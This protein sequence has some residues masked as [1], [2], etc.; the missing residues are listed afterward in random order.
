MKLNN[1]QFKATTV[2]ISFIPGC[3]NTVLPLAVYSSLPTA[4]R[5]FTDASV[6]GRARITARYGSIE[7]ASGFHP[8][9]LLG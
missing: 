8:G 4:R 1:Q 2:R 3:N 9:G 5:D 6:F 7:M